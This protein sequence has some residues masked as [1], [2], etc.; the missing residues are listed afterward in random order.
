LGYLDEFT[1]EDRVDA[2]ILILLLVE[3]HV[4]ACVFAV[5]NTRQVEGL[6]LPVADVLP[7]FEHL[8][9]SYQFANG[10][11]TQLGH[12]FTHLFGHK[13]KHVH[14]MLGLTRK[15]RAQFFILRSNAH[16]TCVEV[17]LPHHDAPSGHQC[18]GSNA[19][20]L[21]TEHRGDD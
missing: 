12:D 16:R 13:R 20:L 15:E 4:E 21:G 3:S 19:K 7:H 1:V 9:L 2:M 14:N 8:N 6:V 17:A 10:A 18:G 5:Q 11:E